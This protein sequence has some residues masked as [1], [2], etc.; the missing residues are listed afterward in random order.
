MIMN[1]VKYFITVDLPILVNIR[2]KNKAATLDNIENARKK[3]NLKRYKDL[4]V[5]NSTLVWSLISSYFPFNDSELSEYINILNC[6]CV[7]ENR[8][9][10]Y[11]NIHKDTMYAIRCYHDLNN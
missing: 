9:L 10:R 2:G 3:I 6:K 7:L 11:M 5:D 1:K 4:P 8:F